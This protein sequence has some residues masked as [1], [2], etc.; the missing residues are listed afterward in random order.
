MPPRNLSSATSSLASTSLPSWP[1]IGPFQITK[2]PSFRP[3]LIFSTLSLV[4][5]GTL[6]LIDTMSMAPSLTPHQVTAALPVP[7]SASLVALM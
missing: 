1:T 5:A 7:S 4:S 3:A 2:L 6:S